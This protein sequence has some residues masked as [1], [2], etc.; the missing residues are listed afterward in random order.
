MVCAIAST[1]ESQNINFL[2]PLSKRI[3]S[4]TFSIS[5]FAFSVELIS[6]L[7]LSFI[8]D[9]AISVAS[10]TLSFNSLVAES[11]AFPIAVLTRR[12]ISVTVS[13]I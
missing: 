10:F 11:I 6:L 9:T 7:A 12:S 2:K 13:V 4:S 3:P 8:L 1:G 5:F